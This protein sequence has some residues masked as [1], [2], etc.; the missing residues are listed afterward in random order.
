MQREGIKQKRHTGQNCGAHSVLGTQGPLL[1]WSSALSPPT[2]GQAGSPAAV[3]P[4]QLALQVLPGP[5]HRV[6]RVA[7]AGPGVGLVLRGGQLERREG[8][9]D[10]AEDRHRVGPAG[11]AAG[12]LWGCD[13]RDG[14][15]RS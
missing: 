2:Q 4:P 3:Q 7:Q 8:P 11:Q 1:P 13:R 14:G 15:R 5:L 9:I 10:G 6:V 12:R